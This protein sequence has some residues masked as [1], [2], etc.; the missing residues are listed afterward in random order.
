MDEREAREGNIKFA[1]FLGYEYFPKGTAAVAGWVKKGLENSVEGLIFKTDFYLGRRHS[2][3][4]FHHNWNSIMKVVTKLE[5]ANYQV[6]IFNTATYIRNV[7]N[8]TL[9]SCGGEDRF[10]ALRKTLLKFID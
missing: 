2:D 7:N 1:R 5:K 10:D 6:S 4:D 3:L 8:T 9:M